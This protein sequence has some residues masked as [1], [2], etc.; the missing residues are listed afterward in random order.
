[1]KDSRSNNQTHPKKYRGW[2]NRPSRYPLTSP[3]QDQDLEPPEENPKTTK[4][5]KKAKSG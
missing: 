2:N 5:Q 4:V 3:A 1:M